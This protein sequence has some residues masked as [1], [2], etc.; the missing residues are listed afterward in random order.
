MPKNSSRAR[1]AHPPLA[2]MTHIGLAYFVD[3]HLQD[4]E[5]AAQLRNQAC[6]WLGVTQAPT[7]DEIRV[8]I[9]KSAFA[10]PRPFGPWISK[11]GL[12][13][14]EVFLL[15]LVGNAE[16]NHV[17]ALSLSELQAPNPVA[18]VSVHLAVDLLGFLFGDDSIDAVR[19]STS[20]LFTSH[21]LGLE[22][23]GPLVLQRLKIDP[24]FWRVLCGYD[25]MWPK[26][27]AIQ[28]GDFLV[29]PD[30]VRRRLPTVATLLAKGEVGGLIIRGSPGSGRGFLAAELAQL[31]GLTAVEI[32]HSEWNAQNLF[33]L[34]CRLAQ[35]LPVVST[36]AADEEHVWIVPPNPPIPYVIQA[37]EGDRIDGQAL[38]E[39][40]T[41]VPSRSERVAIWARCLGDSGLAE[42]SSHAVLP[43]PM[44]VRVAQSAQLRAEMEKVKTTSGHIADARKELCAGRLRL[45]AQPDFR[46]VDKTMV[47]FSPMVGE[48]IGDFIARARKRESVAECLGPT[49]QTTVH[50]GLRALFVGES[51]T[52]K[53]LAASYVAT[54]LG[55]PLF[56]VDLAA[57]MNKYVGESEKN[58]GA[59]LDMG[60]VADV[61]LLFDEA[62]SL[63]G[64]RTEAKQ[65][66]ER[67]A[68]MLTNFLL[69]RIE[70]HPGVVI[71]TTNNKERIDAAFSRRLDVVVEFPMPGFA[72]RLEL[73]RSHLGEK[74]PDDAFC[75]TIAGH[76]ELVGG[77]IRNAVLSAAATTPNDERISTKTLLL[78]LRS[79][80]RKNGR[81]LPPALEVML[82]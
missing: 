18:R 2:A 13:A 39:I 73:W 36:D 59:L 30:R 65:N 55:A 29:L 28:G 56:R 54:E 15:V 14:S 71:L 78:A 19:L 37:K 16:S 4:G 52:G 48:Q 3:T 64:R 74:S 60:A 77:Q 9:L 33:P 20:R 25:T 23:T 76:C 58:L 35:W 53:T 62:D 68:N 27:A 57:I 46:R 67:Y 69:T 40:E 61:I 63:F 6:R 51:G 44:I 22:G 5:L 12:S 31:L 24:A 50:S 66:G 45:L 42:S 47:V 8:S 26:T 17:L 41:Q 7:W 79:E 81:G 80:Y 72:E 21:V 11:S 70:N 49:L 82:R 32:S 34:A 1:N 10:L 75:R 38:L 43:G